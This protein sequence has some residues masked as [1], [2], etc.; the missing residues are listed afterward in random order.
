MM[1]MYCKDNIQMIFD[2]EKILIGDRD[3]FPEYRAVAIF[4]QD[5]VDFVKKSGKMHINSYGIGNYNLW[6]LTIKGIE[7]AATY[8]NICY[9]RDK[10]REGE[11]S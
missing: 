4:G 6:Y 1:Q 8:R 5:A 11:T 10:M 2:R 7:I 9:I 3:V